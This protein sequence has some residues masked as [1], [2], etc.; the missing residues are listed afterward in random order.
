MQAKEWFE[1]SDRDDY[2]G[3]VSSIDM[4]E[5]VIYQS[6]DDDSIWVRPKEEFE[7]RF[8]QVLDKLLKV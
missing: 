2:W 5:V 7:E 3:G 8:E 6:L 4:R 1:A